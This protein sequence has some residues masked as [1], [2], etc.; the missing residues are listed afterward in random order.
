MP[1]IV[2]ARRVAMLPWSTL[3]P[4]RL[5]PT[6]AFQTRCFG[7]VISLGASTRWNDKEMWTE[8]STESP[9]LA[10]RC[11]TTMLL[12]ARSHSGKVAIK[13]RSTS[14][15]EKM[16][17]IANQKLP[18]IKSTTKN[19]AII[20]QALEVKVSCTMTT[21]CSKL[22]MSSEF[23]YVRSKPNRPSSYLK[24]LR[25]LGPSLYT[26]SILIG[27]IYCRQPLILPASVNTMFPF[28]FLPISVRNHSSRH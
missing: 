5:R 11:T 20:E 15:T 23:E 10:T 28:A 26:S 22:S 27:V 24:S 7:F 19:M 21:N 18:V 8:Y 12:N 6:L 16:T 14:R 17:R 13:M 3:E 9:R 1:T 25:Q 2:T 4:I